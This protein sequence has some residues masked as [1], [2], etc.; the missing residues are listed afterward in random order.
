MI[1]QLTNTIARELEHQ[2]AQEVNTANSVADEVRAEQLQHL[3]LLRQNLDLHAQVNA[4]K[5]I[6]DWE[7][8]NHLHDSVEVDM[9]FHH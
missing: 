1:S 6:A 4:A 9:C 3:E 7:T 2:Q 8:H 5:L